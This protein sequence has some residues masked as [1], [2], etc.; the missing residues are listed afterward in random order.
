DGQVIAGWPNAPNLVACHIR[1]PKIAI[2]WPLRDVS[3]MCADRE[4]LDAALDG[5]VVANGLDSPDSA[6]PR[7]SKPE[8]AI[9]TGHNSGWETI[10]SWE[11]KVLDAVGGGDQPSNLVGVALDEPDVVIGST[12]DR[13][14]AA[15]G[16]GCDRWKFCDRAI[17]TDARNAIAV[18]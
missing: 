13:D 14:Q 2:T 8:I 17:A 10:A 12:R 11:F 18:E 5:G 4:L 9:L 7:F 15:P 1:K 3:W 16:I 6:C